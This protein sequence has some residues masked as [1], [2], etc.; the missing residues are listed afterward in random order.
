[1]TGRNIGNLKRIGILFITQELSKRSGGGA[2]IYA[3]EL[4]KHIADRG[5]K[6]HV[7]APGE[8]TYTEHV[9]P[10][11]SIHWH[12]VIN[13]PLLK[14]PSHH[15]Q[16]WAK[17]K[18]IARTHGLSTIHSNNFAGAFAFKGIPQIATIHHPAYDE[19]K[20]ATG[21]QKLLYCPDLFFEKRTI[22][23]SRKIIVPS[24]LVKALLIKNNVRK[25]IHVIP[26]GIDLSFFKKT[27]SLKARASLGLEEDRF[28]IF[29]PGG[30]RAKRKGA[31]DLVKA[32]SQLRNVNF[33]C[34]IT[35][36]SREIGWHKEL[37]NAINNE[38]INDKFIW[39]GEV[40]YKLLPKYYSLADI[41]VYPS[42]FEGFGLPILEA[43]AIGK[44]VICTK[45]GEAPYII[46]NNRNGLLVDGGDSAKLAEA[47]NVL[48]KSAGIRRVL[49]KRGVLTAKEYSW[50][51]AAAKVTNV[52][53]EEML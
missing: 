9:N 5:I 24:H 10:N 48:V 4:S 23:R 21:L 15:F 3:Y 32:F 17:S 46:K 52:H 29:F 49:S 8:K 19:I 41:V 7:M 40:V 42:I 35:G 22:R 50:E 14:V 34:I 38:G 45:T 13:L 25:R 26:N 2:G 27:S 51:T 28:Y 18:K 30:A 39:I 12:R 1:M 11:L 6:T 20:N 44:P 43:L 47:I 16:V 33:K 37:R 36:T 31:L 53:Q